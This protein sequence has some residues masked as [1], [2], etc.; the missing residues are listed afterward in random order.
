MC[1]IDV[2]NKQ[3]SWGVILEPIYFD[4]S[5]K[6]CIEFSS[7]SSIIYIQKVQ[8]IKYGPSNL[9]L[10]SNLLPSPVMLLF[11]VEEGAEPG[12]RWGTGARMC[13][14][15]SRAGILWEKRER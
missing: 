10:R 7:L 1:V 14:C 15:P 11:G 3:G 4:L 5:P 12:Q 13:F 9:N 6:Q 2:V 8:P